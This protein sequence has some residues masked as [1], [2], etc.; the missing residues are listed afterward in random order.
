MYV[1]MTFDMSENVNV[2]RKMAQH[3]LCNKQD[4]WGVINVYADVQGLAFEPCLML[5]GA[6]LSL[7]SVCEMHTV[8]DP[9]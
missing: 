8:R 2:I 9:R 7:V 3:I 5:L 4:I 6:I 1:V